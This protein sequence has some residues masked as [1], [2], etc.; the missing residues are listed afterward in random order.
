MSNAFYDLDAQ[1]RWNQETRELLQKLVDLIATVERRGSGK[2]TDTLHC[3][4]PMKWRAKSPCRGVE[5]HCCHRTCADEL[6]AWIHKVLRAAG[7]ERQQEY[8]K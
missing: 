1:M 2:T 8:G 7:R 5:E 4:L 6:E 3:D